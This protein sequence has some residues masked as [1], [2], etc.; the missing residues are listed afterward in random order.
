M[1]IG[2]IDVIV[3]CLEKT[4]LFAVGYFRTY[5]RVFF[6]RI[7]GADLFRNFLKNSTRS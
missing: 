3:S 6:L 7:F 2:L 4:H 5:A 1:G